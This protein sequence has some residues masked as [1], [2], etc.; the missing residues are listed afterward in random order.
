MRADPQKVFGIRL[1]KRRQSLGLSQEGLAEQCRLHRTYVGSI[2]RG[3][4]N[5]SLQNIV[6]LARALDTTPSSLLKGI[7]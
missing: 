4:R 1:R 6:K 3:E 2:E 5:I 7:S